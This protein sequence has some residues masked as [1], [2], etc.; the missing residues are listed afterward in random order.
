MLISNEY[1]K[2]STL[3]GGVLIHLSLGSFETFGNFT[4]YLTSYLREITGSSCRYSNSIWIFS[5]V[6]IAMITSAVV[7]GLF[8]SRFRPNLKLVIFIGCLFMRFFP[9]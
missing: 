4:P 5:S 1:K 7:T 6:S 8:V 9:D 3:I 2:W